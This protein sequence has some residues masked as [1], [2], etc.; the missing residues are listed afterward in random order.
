METHILQSLQCALCLLTFLFQIQDGIDY[1]LTWVHGPIKLMVHVSPEPSKEKHTQALAFG[2]FFVFFKTGSRIK[3]S[4]D[5]H[6]DLKLWGRVEG[7]STGWFLQYK[8]L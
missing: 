2:G 7:T 3:K 5:D 6:T 4:K 8:G 1:R